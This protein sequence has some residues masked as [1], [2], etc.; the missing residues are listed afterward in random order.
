MLTY[1]GRK[2]VESPL[3]SVVIEQTKNGQCDP[4]RREGALRHGSKAHRV[5]HNGGY[6][7]HLTEPL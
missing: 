7:I 5:G 2:V 4:I 6:V 1:S 3:T